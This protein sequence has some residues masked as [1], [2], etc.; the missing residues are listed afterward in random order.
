MK[1]GSE[2]NQTNLEHIGGGSEDLR[3]CGFMGFVGT[4]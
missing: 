4:T 3:T 1:D 2:R